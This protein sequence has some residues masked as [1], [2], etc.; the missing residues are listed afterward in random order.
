MK[1]LITLLLAFTMLFSL[2]ACGGES[3]TPTTAEDQE[4]EPQKYELSDDVIESIV[5]RA[6]YE[7]IDST[8]DTADAGS[9]TYGIN[10][11]EKENGYIYV[12]GSVTLYDKYGRATSGWI[13]GSGTPYKS[14]TVKIDEDTGRLSSCN[15]D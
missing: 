8:F 14:F 10:K 15:I 6:L 7:E 5:V 1:R 3:N 12:Y 2:C 9:C 4:Y 13:T 11:T